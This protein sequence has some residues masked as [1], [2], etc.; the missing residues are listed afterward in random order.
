MCV[1][2]AVRD[3][4]REKELKLRHTSVQRDLPRPTEVTK[5]LKLLMLITDLSTKIQPQSVYISAYSSIR[6]FCMFVGLL[7]ILFWGFV[8]SVSISLLRSFE[9]SF[10]LCFYSIMSLMKDGGRHQ[11]LSIP[12]QMT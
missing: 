9:E 10:F 1:C 11:P 2:Q 7:E 4:E 12:F 5:S 8:A 6:E 3:A